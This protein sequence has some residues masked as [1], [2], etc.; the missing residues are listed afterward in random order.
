MS[1]EV[2]GKVLEATESGFLVSQDDWDKD[3][4]A[5]IAAAE[6]LTLT[7]DRLLTHAVDLLKPGGILVYAVCSLQEDEGPV[8]VAALLGRRSD[9]RRLPVAATELPGLETAVTV[10][11]DVRT[12]PPMGVDGFY[13]ARLTVG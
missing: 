8:R 12:L 5:A 3:V 4:A 9:I 7:Q 2:N 1:Y 10:D 6:G 11:G 13:I